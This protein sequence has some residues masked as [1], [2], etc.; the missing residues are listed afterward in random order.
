[1]WRL[2]VSLWCHATFPWLWVDESL[3]F[4]RTTS[5]S[6]AT[7]LTEIR[8]FGYLHIRHFHQDMVHKW[9]VDHGVQPPRVVTLNN[10]IN[11]ELVKILCEKNHVLERAKLHMTNLAPS[12][13]TEHALLFYRTM[14]NWCAQN[15]LRHLDID[16]GW[17]CTGILRRALRHTDSNLDSVRH[18]VLNTK[19]VRPS[20]CIPSFHV[21]VNLKTLVW[22]WKQ[23]VATDFTP[24]LRFLSN[25]LTRLELPRS[26]YTPHSSVLSFQKL[27]ILHHLQ[28]TGKECPVMPQLQ[29]FHGA[30]YASMLN[31]QLLPQ[32]ALT[33]RELCVAYAS[34]TYHMDQDYN[35]DHHLLLANNLCVPHLT[36]LVL[37]GFLP[38]WD[39]NVSPFP[40]LEVLEVYPRL[41]TGRGDYNNNLSRTATMI[42]LCTVAQGVWTL[43]YLC[44]LAWHVEHNMLTQIHAPLL[45]ELDLTIT[46]NDDDDDD[47]GDGEQESNDSKN[48]KSNTARYHQ[49]WHNLWPLCHKIRVLFRNMTTTPL[50]VRNRLRRIWLATPNLMEMEVELSEQWNYSDEQDNRSET[51]LITEF[52]W[53]MS[54]FLRDPICWS[55][56]P[57]KRIPT[58]SPS[59]T[60]CSQLPYAGAFVL[61][62]NTDKVGSGAHE[63]WHNPTQTCFDHLTHALVLFY[64]SCAPRP[65]IDIRFKT[66][67]NTAITQKVRTLIFITSLFAVPFFPLLS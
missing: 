46:N 32:C 56:S 51:T 37:N 26:A 16:G 11:V 8:V 21:F 54:A 15:R 62:S 63:Y 40:K 39:E 38:L 44:R 9:I 14:F 59:V 6:A 27:Q 57:S 41:T 52:L 64:R 53:C 49:I 13:H 10:V 55:F 23:D 28:F 20:F 43:P 47:A 58:A 19:E 48:N 1:M 45:E 66:A 60:F 5:R 31:T 34:P 33:L 2:P 17:W 30:I 35:R 7:T 65:L 18:L 24:V 25:H 22:N 50:V 4:F 67:L 3:F 36:R 12:P 42:V 29:V 61:S